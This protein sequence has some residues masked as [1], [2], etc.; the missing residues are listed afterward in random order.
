MMVKCG[1]DAGKELI[2]LHSQAVGFKCGL[3]TQAFNDIK[4][5]QYAEAYEIVETKLT[6]E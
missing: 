3:S 5:G 2:L 6:S 1:I 4:L